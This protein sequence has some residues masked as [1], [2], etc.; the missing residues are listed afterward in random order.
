[1]QDSCCF[2]FFNFFFYWLVRY[3]FLF[4]ACF[5][6]CVSSVFAMQYFLSIIAHPLTPL[7]IL[8]FDSPPFK[9]IFFFNNG[10]KKSKEQIK[11]QSKRAARGKCGKF[12]RATGWEVLKQ[13]LRWLVNKRKSTN[14]FRTNIACVFFP[15]SCVS[16]TT[17]R[18]RLQVKIRGKKFKDAILDASNVS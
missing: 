8:L 12:E 17:L 16:L 2:C 3:F 6:W 1:M 9:L 13:Y 7:S 18:R 11:N 15:I 14:I 4:V 5:A 10:R